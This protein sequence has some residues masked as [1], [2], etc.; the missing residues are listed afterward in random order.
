MR[1]STVN[2]V[3]TLSHPGSLSSKLASISATPT[4]LTSTR[5]IIPSTGSIPD[6]LSTLDCR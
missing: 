4:Q 5:F 6:D 2:G 1:I 3:W